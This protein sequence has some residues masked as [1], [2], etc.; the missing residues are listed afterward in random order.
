ML[1]RFTIGTLFLF[2]MCT[3]GWSFGEG[4]TYS[5]TKKISMGNCEIAATDITKAQFEFL[6]FDRL[7]QPEQ[8][9]A[10]SMPPP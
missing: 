1:K 8:L 5:P 10:R 6:E 4:D 2:G 3:Q 9:S 7:S